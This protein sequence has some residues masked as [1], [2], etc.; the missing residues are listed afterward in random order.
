MASDT[1]RLGFVDDLRGV[2]VVCM[3]LW[4]SVDGWLLRG[5]RSGPGYETLRFFGGMA[6]PLFLLLAGVGVGMKVAADMERQRPVELTRRGLVSRGLFI[7]TLGYG[8]RLQMWMLDSLAVIHP[9]AWRAWLPMLIGLVLLGLGSERLA[10]PGRRPLQLLAPGGLILAL[11]IHQLT[12]VAPHRVTGLLRVDVLQ[13]IGASIILLGGLAESL[14][15]AKRPWRA[16]TLALLMTLITPF[17][18]AWVPGPLPE[19]VAGYLARWPTPPGERPVAMFPLF[20]WL[21]YAWVGFAVGV[22]WLRRRA[23]IVEAVLKLAVVGAL[24]SLAVRETSPHVRA[25]LDSLPWL[26]PTCRVG[27]RVGVALVFSAACL[28]LLRRFPR[29]PWRT[30][31]QTSLLIY[32]VHLEFVYGISSRPIS[33]SLD[34]GAWALGFALLCSAMYALSRFRL[35]PFERR[36]QK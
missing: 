19:V 3:M 32:W 30:F 29:N 13:C 31:G 27:Y 4:H 2:A 23:K 10:R 6:A 9:G 11:G 25:L 14:G 21:S 20:P 15:L 24:L 35:G 12:L 8:L 16:L 1:Q 17:M 26:T 36:R 22:Y 5:I 33:R 18:A 7:L 34:Y 28:L